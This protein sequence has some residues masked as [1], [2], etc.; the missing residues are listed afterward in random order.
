MS[1][2]PRP[3][4]GRTRNSPA[5]R[6]AARRAERLGRHHDDDGLT[7]VELLVAFACLMVLLGIVSTA[8]TTYLTAGTT[9][10]SSYNSTDELLPGSIVM[11]RLVRSQVEPAPS[12][13]TTAT[14]CAVVNQDCPPFV[15]GSVGTYST[16]FFANVGDSNGPALIVMAEGTPTECGTC[17]FY[18]SVFTVTEYPAKAS[19]CPTS[20]TATTFCHYQ[21]AT[22][23]QAADSTAPAPKVLVDVPN[24]VNGAATIAGGS[25]PLPYAT[26][27]LFTYNTLDSVSNAYVPNNGGTANSAGILPGFSTT[28]TAPSATSQ[29]CLADTVQSV[30]I[31][32]EVQTQGSPVQESAFVVY[33]LSSS[34]YLY[35][36]LVG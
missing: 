6:W 18:S 7:L 11:Q 13:T 17:R 23:F 28:C 21:L 16:T 10:I 12:P 20:L 22:W 24:V 15:T 2:Y 36:T 34:S 29:N 33:R 4:T 35:S 31:D 3:G 1:R 30:G 19:T 32:L 27:P 8:L 25:T 9:V 5:D 14:A 26:T